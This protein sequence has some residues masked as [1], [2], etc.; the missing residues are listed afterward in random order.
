MTQAA[1]KKTPPSKKSSIDEAFGASDEA[2]QKADATVRKAA[3]PLYQVS[4]N[5]MKETSFARNSYTIF[6][7]P[8]KTLEQIIDERYYA[9]VAHMLRPNDRIE[10]I[11]EDRTWMHE[12]MVVEVGRLHARV[13]VLRSHELA[14]PEPLPKDSPYRVDFAGDEWRVLQGADVI[15]EGFQTQASAARWAKEHQR[16]LGR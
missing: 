2:K 10:V 3:V 15:K 13:V 6:E 14:K 7:D 9:H 16:A 5:R 4:K 12:L 11:A 1:K 8:A